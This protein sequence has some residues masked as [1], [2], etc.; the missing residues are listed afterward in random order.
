MTKSIIFR[1]AKNLHELKALLKLRY[2][3]YLQSACASLIQP[4]RYQIDLD[5]Y[6]LRALHFGVFETD[7]LRAKPIGYV[8]FI[9]E[10]MT[11][12]APMIWQLAFTHPELLA[13]L[14][15]DASNTFPFLQYHPNQSSMELRIAKARAKG[16]R[17]LEA[18]RF[19]FDPQIRSAGILNFTAEATLAT[20]F[21]GLSYDCLMLVC[22]P[23]HCRFYQRLGFQFFDEGIQTSYEKL[24]ARFMQHRAQQLPNSYKKKMITMGCQ[25]DQYGSIRSKITSSMI[26]KK[27]KQLVKAA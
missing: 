13:A 25:Y 14:Q 21:F 22:N 11:S 7:G 3:G 20:L 8:R 27:R 19:V 17:I 2:Q 16:E 26:A 4:N 6:D 15:K 9:Q 18:S 10:E 5:V 12:T 1:Q 24:P 23:S